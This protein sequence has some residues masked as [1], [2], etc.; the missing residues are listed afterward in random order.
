[1][2]RLL[3]F[4]LF[5]S[6]DRISLYVL[7]EQEGKILFFNSHDEDLVPSLRLLYQLQTLFPDL[8]AMKTIKV[9]TGAIK[10]LLGGSNIMRPGVVSLGEEAFEAGEYLV[11]CLY[12]MVDRVSR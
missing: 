6:H 4:C 1:M 11:L 10:P 12:L 9:D 8:T 7:E 3:L 5:D 2:V